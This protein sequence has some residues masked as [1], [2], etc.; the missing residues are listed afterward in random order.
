MV[1]RTVLG[2]RLGDDE[3]VLIDGL[4]RPAG[5]PPPDLDAEDLEP[6]GI[7]V[8]RWFLGFALVLLNL[9]DVLMTKWIIAN[10]GQEANPVMKPIIDDP[11]APLVVKCGMALMIGWLLLISPRERRFVDRATLAVVIVYTVVIGWNI[12]VM[13][14]ASAAA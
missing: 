4:D 10:G 6:A 7:P 1:P 2:V 14:E 3:R 9:V 11:L 13:L 12:S 8:S 5:D